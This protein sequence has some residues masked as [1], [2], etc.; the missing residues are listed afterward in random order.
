MYPIAFF[1]TMTGN[2]AVRSY[3]IKSSLA[4]YRLPF[5]LLSHGIM[6]G[7]STS[8]FAMA[9]KHRGPDYQTLLA[10]LAPVNKLISSFEDVKYCHIYV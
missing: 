10:K 4:I 7:L 8:L 9:G 5:V 6:H 1:F 3:M 2:G